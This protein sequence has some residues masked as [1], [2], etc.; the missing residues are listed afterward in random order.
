ML[1]WKYT[2]ILHGITRIVF[3]LDL[4]FVFKFSSLSA[5]MGKLFNFLWS[6]NAK[7]ITQ[8]NLPTWLFYPYLHENIYLFLG[9]GEY[10][11]FSVFGST[12][13]NRRISKRRVG[14]R[15]SQK[16]TPFCCPNNCGRSYAHRQSLS[17]HLRYECGVEPQFEC[18]LCNKKFT[19]H[20]TL[21]SHRGLV[22]KILPW[23]WYFFFQH[24]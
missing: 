7:I 11:T 5:L 1:F 12:D 22:H 9:S 24:R 16:P 13:G 4:R 23:C 8:M 20:S 21:K 6:R 15:N 10:S 3:L 2:Y 14:T 17:F 19:K 18:E